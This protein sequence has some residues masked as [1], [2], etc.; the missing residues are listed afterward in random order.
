MAL[1]ILSA[2]IIKYSCPVEHRKREANTMAWYKVIFQS[3]KS[4]GFDSVAFE[5]LD[6]AS[7]FCRECNGFIMEYHEW[8]N[9]KGHGFWKII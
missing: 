5:T 4:F 8:I 6:L 2:L 9:D 7:R 3:K 1:L